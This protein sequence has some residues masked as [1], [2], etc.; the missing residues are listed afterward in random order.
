MGDKKKKKVTR[1]IEKGK[2][3]VLRIED[4][5]VRWVYIGKAQKDNRST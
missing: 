3:Y 4:S 1:M 5:C 2:E